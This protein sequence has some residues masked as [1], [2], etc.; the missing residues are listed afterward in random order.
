[1]GVVISLKKLIESNRDQLL[2]SVMAVYRG[3]LTAIGESA[4][5]ACPAVG[6]ALQ[7]KL[8]SFEPVLCGDP[9]C[10]VVEETGQQVRTEIELWGEASA[11]FYQQRTNDVKEIMLVLA[12]TAEALGRRDERYQ[13]QFR[14]FTCQ[15]ENIARLED[16]TL[17]RKSLLRS[18]V[19]LRTCTETMAREGRESVVRLC[20]EVD[21]YEVKLQ[22]AQRLAATD[23]LTGLS[24]RLR[25]EQAI[26]A[27]LAEDRSFSVILLDLNGLKQINDT[28]GHPAGDDAL[29]Q[30]GTELKSVFRTG[31]VVGRWGGYEF[32]VVVDG[33]ESFAGTCMERIRTW[34]FGDYTLASP[35]G[36]LKI[37]MSASSGVA[38]RR[39]G[40]TMENLVERADAA[41]YRDKQAGR[42]TPNRSDA[43]TV[44]LG[45]DGTS[46]RTSN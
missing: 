2:Q 22:E 16:L 34:A 28:H 7:A 38:T 15:L 9:T 31:D 12:Q 18:A 14:D 24:N 45:A 43:S 41:M 19:T 3:A 23:P 6:V 35:R 11:V 39:P 27:R 40:D 30:F 4:A 1:V 44:P 29:K 32:M 10:A 46:G 36:P 21:K 20:R 37:P 5:K 26:A 13:N 25:V 17:V 42:T 33:G 8:A